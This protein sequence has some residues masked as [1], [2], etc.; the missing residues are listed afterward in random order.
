MAEVGIT[1]FRDASPEQ[2]AEFRKLA[3]E[4]G[5]I[6]AEPT[7]GENVVTTRTVY[8]LRGTDKTAV[9]EAV[10]VK[11]GITDGT[12]SEIVDGLAEGDVIITGIA[13]PSVTAPAGQPATNPF[14][15]GRRF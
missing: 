13:Q 5:L 4:R 6:P 10:N 9:P 8:R 3:V 11:V 14:G 15:G 12:A 7:P 2:R 1:S